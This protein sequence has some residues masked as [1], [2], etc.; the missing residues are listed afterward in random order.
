ME[1]PSI[2]EISSARNKAYKQGLKEPTYEP[3]PSDEECDWDII[4]ID[5][6]QYIVSGDQTYKLQELGQRVIGASDIS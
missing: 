6:I 2:D 1:K 3:E 4:V 5:G